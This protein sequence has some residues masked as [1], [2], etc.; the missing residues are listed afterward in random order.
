MDAQK[1][2]KLCYHKRLD[3]VRI[4]PEEERFHFVPES[5]FVVSLLVPDVAED[6]SDFLK[7]KAGDHDIN[8][9]EAS[10]FDISLRLIEVRCKMF[11]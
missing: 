2:G 1:G 4:E 8:S 6:D 11:L 5:E 7:M 10:L 9:C 3:F